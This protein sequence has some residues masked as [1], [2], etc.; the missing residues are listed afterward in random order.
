VRQER[1]AAF[2][3]FVQVSGDSLVRLSFALCG[4]R[5]AAEDAAQEALTGVYLRWGRLDDPLPYARR[6]VVNATNDQWRRLS[7]RER[8]ERAVASRPPESP[9]LLDDMVADRDR[10][11][12]ALQRQHGRCLAPR[13]GT[14]T[15]PSSTSSSPN[16]RT[17]VDSTVRP[18]PG[19]PQRADRYAGTRPA[20]VPRQSRLRPRTHA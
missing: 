11:M 17:S 19:A 7:R 8:R 13:T 12:N 4:D 2:E 6:A 3:E 9:A 1:L 18:S 15:P 16:S 10:L 20:S 14:G 5:G